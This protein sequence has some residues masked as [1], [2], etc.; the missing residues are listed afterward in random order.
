MNALAAAGK[1]N[2]DMDDALLAGT[3]GEGTED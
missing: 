2:R 3:N 1:M